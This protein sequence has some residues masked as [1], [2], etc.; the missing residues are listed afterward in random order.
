MEK[1]PC[2]IIIMDGYGYSPA[3]RGNAVKAANA[4]V[5]ENLEKEYPSTLIG[6]SGMD[7]GLPYKTATFLKTPR[8]K[9]RSIPQGITAKNFIYTDF[10]LRVACIRI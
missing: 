4:K 2:C 10:C 5:I 6:A 3:V 8:L 1:R 7:V 9:G